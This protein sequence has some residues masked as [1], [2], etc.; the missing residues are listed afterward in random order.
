MRQ[1][2]GGDG[3]ELARSVSP[4]HVAGREAASGGERT[5]GGN[6][7][8]ATSR[9]SPR[10]IEKAADVSVGLGLT[11]SGMGAGGRIEK[12]RRMEDEDAVLALGA[13]I[14]GAKARREGWA[15]P[16]ESGG[17]REGETRPG[18]LWGKQAMTGPG[19]SDGGSRHVY[20]GDMGHAKAQRTLGSIA[21][22]VQ[23]CFERSIFM[24][25]VCVM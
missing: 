25:L 20:L 23:V 13:S 14:G 10:S 16:S 18:E 2:D 6:D 19:G 5:R 4:P 12:R 9:R 8:V 7:L 3:R 15:V 21:Q 11:G 22:D 17:L 24:R 1:G